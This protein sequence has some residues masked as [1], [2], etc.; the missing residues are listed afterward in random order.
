MLSYFGPD[1][2]SY[3]I[4][5]ALALSRHDSARWLLQRAFDF[6]AILSALML[7]SCPVHC[8]HL[9]SATPF[10]CNTLQHLSDLLVA[11]FYPP[12][13][14]PSVCAIPFLSQHLATPSVCCYSDGAVTVM[15]TSTAAQH[16]FDPLVSCLQHLCNN[17]L[18]N[19][20][21]LQHLPFETPSL[22]N[23]CLLHHF[24]TPFCRNTFLFATPFR[25]LQCWCGDEDR[26]DR[27]GAGACDFQC[28]GNEYACGGYFSTTTY[29]LTDVVELEPEVVSGATY[30]DCYNDKAGDRTMTLK[31]KS[32]A[33]TA[34]V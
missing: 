3:V 16:D 15:W 28:G 4:G 21:L 7:L 13:L 19:T 12:C 5:Y 14:L 32:D 24:P 22:S 2:S 20:F 25:D 17:I 23:T 9:P 10:L 34:K 33:M 31:G 30:L 18:C 1:S 6:D 29:Q 26:V 11:D 27:H 8:L